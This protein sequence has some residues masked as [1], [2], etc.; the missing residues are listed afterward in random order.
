MGVSRRE[1]VLGG[2][3]GA[4]LGGMGAALAA[5]VPPLSLQP[6]VTPGYRPGDSDERGMW[7]ACE[8]LEQRIAASNLLIADA[9]LHDYLGAVLQ[10][11]LGELHANVRHYVV[12][13]A[14]FNASMFPNGMTLVHT[15]LLARM[16]D[17]GQLAAVLGHESGHYLRRH[18]LQ[19][20]RSIKKKSAAMALISLAGAAASGSTG[21]DWYGMADAINGAL[22]LSMFSYSREHESEADAYGL[23][24][25]SAAHYPPHCA[26]QI[27]EQL[28]A[29]RRASAAVR[30]KKYRDPASSALS[31]HPPTEVRLAELTR[32][33]AEIEQVVPGPYD[34]RRTAWRAAIGPFRPMLLDEQ[35]KLNDAGASLYLLD[36]LAQDGWDSLLRYYQGEAYRLRDE[37]GDAARAAEAYAAAVQFAEVLPEAYRAHGYALI[38]NGQVAAGRQALARYLAARPDAA[39]AEMVRFTLAQ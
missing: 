27:W 1:F 26:A 16:R 29:E 9:G 8:R 21:A 17:E 35:V 22:V 23:K 2:L 10:R 28:I 39:D 37:S 19:N 11:L 33:A 36:S 4:A 3:C 25:L 24:L 38:K 18:S 34:E 6:L 20:W 30:N 14:S 5:G 13:D 15:G 31:T 7:Q 32:A 12:R